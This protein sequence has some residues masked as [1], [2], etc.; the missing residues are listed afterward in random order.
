[1]LWNG[2]ECEGGGGEIAA[3]DLKASIP[4]TDYDRSKTA[5]ECGIFQLLRYNYDKGGKMLA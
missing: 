3:E 1:M 5:A 2:N 4:N